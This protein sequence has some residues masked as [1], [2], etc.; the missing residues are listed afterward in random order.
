ML[1]P[2]KKP[3]GLRRWLFYLTLS[4][5]LPAL[6][7][8]GHAIL[9]F[10]R[11]ARA[12]VIDNLEHRSTALQ[13]SLEQMIKVATTTVGVLAD[14]DS[15]QTGDWRGLYDQ[16]KRSISHDGPVRAVSLVD[17][18]GDVIFHTSTPFGVALFKA[19]DK[20][21]VD[22]ALQQGRI[23]VSGA[24]KAPIS[25]KS[26]VAVSVPLMQGGQIRHVLRAIILTESIDSLLAE[27]KLPEDWVAG[28]TDSRGTLLA[29]SLGSEKF[30]GT[31]ASASFLEGMRRGGGK[32]FKG[33]T[34]EGVRTTF[35]VMPV[36]GGDWFL[37]LSVPESV[38]GAP[39]DRAL[40]ELAGFGLLWFAL[41]LTMAYAFGTYIIRQAQ[42]LVD[43][44]KAQPVVLRAP[45]ALGVNEFTALLR[46]VTAV[47][48]REAESTK[49]MFAARAQRDEVFDLYENA[50]CGY[51]SLDRQGRLVRM[52]ATALGW[53]GYRWD[54]VQGRPMMDLLTPDSQAR[55][56]ETFP[57]FLQTEHIEGVELMLVR[58]DGST[59]PASINATAIKDAEGNLISSRS[60]V[61]DITEHK[62]LEA[63]LNLLARTDTLTGLSNLRDF[64]ERGEREL[65]RH[66][67]HA[68][69][70]AVLMM[71][72]DH[73]KTIN[74]RYGHDGGDLVLAEV[75]KSCTAVLR[76]IDLVARVGGEEFAL[77]L[78]ETTVESAAEVADRLRQS[79]ASLSVVLPTG[80]TVSLTV[81][82]GVAMCLATDAGL[83]AGLK[84]AD[85]ALY[86]A[87]EGGRNQV[88]IAVPSVAP[89]S[90]V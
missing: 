12:A 35:V 51:H 36:Q 30:V 21:S 79:L 28:V 44:V 18:N 48:D 43:A 53:L 13:Q 8:A 72:I 10:D 37:G 14:S 90:P 80:Q 75:A 82:I 32:P 69:S 38:L 74:D 24:F 63:Q 70:L 47:Q 2:F 40:A 68:A 16:A 6:V 22:A 55:F 31:P 71:D 87:K 15:A 66:Q 46:G 76:N 73:F 49:Q 4:A 60:T 42:V 3:I 26:V 77:M 59:F 84:R 50:P 89:A 54:E 9:E 62:R 33:S 81:S 57:R 45:V 29:R 83:D 20:A 65:R 56:T 5:L 27:A 11:V 19:N 88:K 52:N 17:G 23:S 58:K 61:F 64:V 67:R 85:L 1:A 41:A 39:L 78:P 25:P 34:L 7:F 86:Q